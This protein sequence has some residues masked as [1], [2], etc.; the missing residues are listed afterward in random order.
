[1]FFKGAER[2]RKHFF[3]YVRQMPL[4]LPVP[5]RPL[6]QDEN[7]NRCPLVPNQFE[8]AAGRIALVVDLDFVG[9]GYHR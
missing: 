1:M 4:Q 8:Q 7:D 2:L 5:L 9:H 6:P 3:G